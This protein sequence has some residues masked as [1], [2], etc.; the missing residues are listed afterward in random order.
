MVTGT[1]AGLWT[2]LIGTFIPSIILL[3]LFLINID[4]YRKSAQAIANQK[5]LNITYTNSL[6]IEGLVINFVILLA[7]GVLIGAVGGVVGGQF[8]RRRAQVPPVEEYKEAMFEPPQS[9]EEEEPASASGVEEAAT[10][11][12]EIAEQTAETSHE[13]PSSTTQQ[14]E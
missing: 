4:A 3:V 2:G 1:L 12:P 9:S 10:S 5:H 13:E 8:G 7:L 14:T 6:L 11:T